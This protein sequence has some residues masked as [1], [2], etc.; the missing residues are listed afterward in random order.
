[1]CGIAGLLY[2]DQGRV[3]PTDRL[4]RMRD[5]EGPMIAGCTSM[6]RSGWLTGV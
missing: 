6:V 3:C 4:I 5:I 1:M 2:H